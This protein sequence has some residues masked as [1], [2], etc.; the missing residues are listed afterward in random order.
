M[1]HLRVQRVTIVLVVLEVFM[2]AYIAMKIINTD[3]ATVSPES[4]R[5]RIPFR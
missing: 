4:I 3:P 2:I 5:F 1:D